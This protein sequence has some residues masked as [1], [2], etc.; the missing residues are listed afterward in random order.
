MIFYVVRQS[1]AYTIVNYLES[2]GIKTSASFVRPLFY[3][4]LWQMTI[5]PL[6]TYIFSDIERLNPD[7]AERSARIWEELANSGKGIRLLN[8]PTRSK[9]RYELLR[10]L[11]LKGINQFNVYRLTEHRQPEKFPVFIRG[12]NDHRGSRTGLI[13]TPTELDQAVSRLSEAGESLDNKIITEFCSTAD[14]DGLFRKYSS[15]IVG[16]EI[17]PRHLFF[18]Y[19][20]MIK[21]PELVEERN[22]LE[23]EEYVK[24][25]PHE[26]MLRSIFKLANIDYGRIDYS[27]IDGVP[28][29]WEINTNPM[30]LSIKDMVNEL[31]KKRVVT[32]SYFADTFASELKFIN[33]ER[34]SSIKIFLSTGPSKYRESYLIKVAKFL[35]LSLLKILPYPYQL[36]TRLKIRTW[37]KSLKR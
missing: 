27:L 1:S 6:G 16:G 17:I 18:N 31:Q 25:N 26:S 15:F 28:Q 24:T 22:L 36:S 9:R 37:L 12:E 20:W 33:D 8:H 10:S 11:Y 13:N 4:Q 34:P 5:L 23:E 2:W 21:C 32:H 14:Q 3:E 19:Q 30:S 35:P 7:E 29:V